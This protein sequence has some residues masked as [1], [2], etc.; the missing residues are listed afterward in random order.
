MGIIEGAGTCS[1][2]GKPSWHS[3]SNKCEEHRPAKGGRP[4]GRARQP[5]EQT[6]AARIV[7]AL[8]AID[9]KTFSGKTPTAAEW[10][11]KLT[12]VVVLLTM[13]YIEYAVIKPSDLAEPY[14]TQMTERL[15]MTED[16][17]R[18]IVEPVAHAISGTKVN[19]DHGREAIELLAFAPA[20]L[21]VLEWNARVQRFKKEL[22]SG[23]V[24]ILP[25]P[26]R[27]E[28]SGNGS[29]RRAEAPAP[30]E[31]SSGVPVANFGGGGGVWDPSEAPTA[32]VHRD[33]AELDDPDRA[34]EAAH[35]ALN[36][37]AGDPHAWIGV[38]RED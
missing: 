10:E 6:T 8:P 26:L 28:E 23:E 2:C 24:T 34:L 5:R 1:V 33:G 30:A 36:G 13:T 35:I 14:A 32:R 12:A 16:E 11:E 15:G 18:T 38:P 7:G 25:E 9:A 19:K 22:K 20:L 4:P 27:Q 21:A 29:H 37:A 31:R 3:R 17:A